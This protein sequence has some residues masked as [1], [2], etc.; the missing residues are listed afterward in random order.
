MLGKLEYCFTHIFDLII[1]FLD[2]KKSK[3]IK[4][5]GCLSLFFVPNR[6]NDGSL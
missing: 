1:K 3:K 2:K 4:K 6:R 5:T